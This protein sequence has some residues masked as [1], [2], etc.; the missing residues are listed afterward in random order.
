MRSILLVICLFT[1]CAAQAQE[2]RPS[3][4]EPTPSVP[5]GANF[6]YAAGMGIGTNEKDAIDA[7]WVDA[8]FNA[9]QE[10]GHI[11]MPQKKLDGIRTKRDLDAYIAANAYPIHSVCQTHSIHLP[12]GKVKVYILLAIG[13]YERVDVRNVNVDCESRTFIEA[14]KQWNDGIYPFSPRVFVPGMAQIYKGSTGKGVAF[15]VG[16]ISLVGGVVVAESLRASYKAKD[17]VSL[18]DDFYAD[19]ADNMQNIRNW[20]IAG[21]IGLYAWNVIDGWMAPGKKYV[22]VLSYNNFRI[23]PYAAPHFNGSAMGGLA[24][25]LKF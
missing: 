12:G 5:I 2:P 14:L 1:V 17:N 8:F 4:Y 20:V 18:Y 3:W 13:N 21:A 9:A 11:A 23:Y 25:S 22:G 16:E 7:A 19:K 24:L 15:I 10:K 6:I